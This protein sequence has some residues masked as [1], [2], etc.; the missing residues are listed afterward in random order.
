MLENLGIATEGGRARAKNVAAV[1]VTANMPPFVQSGA[2][3]DISV[4]SLG[5]ATSLAW[6]HAGH[7]AAE[8]R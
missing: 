2:R 8:G 3:I 4:S 1:I 6:R 5:D 7:D